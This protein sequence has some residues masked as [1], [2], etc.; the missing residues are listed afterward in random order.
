GNI[1]LS[2]CPG[3]KVRLSGPIK[4]RAAINRDLC[5]DFAR[6]ASLS[7]TT[8][9]CCLDDK[10]LDY[11]GAPWL[12]Y[13]EAARAHHIDI[14]RLPMV[15]G[16]CPSTVD[17]VYQVIR[18][19]NHTVMEGHHVLVHCR[20]G[21]GRAGLFVCCWLLENRL[22]ASAER[23]IHYVRVRR[24]AKAIET[25]RQAEFIIRYGQFASHRA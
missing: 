4:G 17:E 8:V 1:A 2:S 19:V 3:K 20:G 21:V 18:H 11:L 9:V 12:K 25:M 16:S 13:Y 22:C 15:E 23:A 6:M 14:I 24:S 10:E 5:L 7:V